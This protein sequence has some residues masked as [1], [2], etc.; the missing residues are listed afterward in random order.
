MEISETWE[1]LKME[2]KTQQI[3]NIFNKI[4]FK[5]VFRKNSQGWGHMPLMPALG[6]KKQEVIWLAER[7]LNKAD[8]DKSSA[9]FVLRIL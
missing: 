6:N 4:L 5:K 9:L 8:V 7:G 2:T 3:N 1:N